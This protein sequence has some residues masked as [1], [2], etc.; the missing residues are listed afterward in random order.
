MGFLSTELLLQTKIKANVTTREVAA[1]LFTLRRDLP[2][3]TQ[4]PLFR[5][6]RH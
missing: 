4:V 3:S 2:I 1:L 6:T 5:P